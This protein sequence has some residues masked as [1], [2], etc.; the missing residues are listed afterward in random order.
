VV[1]CKHEK[2]GGP[3]EICV[4]KLK[5]IK[6]NTIIIKNTVI[7]ERDSSSEFVSI[8]DGDSS[9]HR[10]EEKDSCVSSMESV[11]ISD[12]DSSDHKE[13]EKD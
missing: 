7:E 5:T 10:E 6:M 2:K 13:E 12:G 9:D 4:S 11:S 1:K 3:P 8:R